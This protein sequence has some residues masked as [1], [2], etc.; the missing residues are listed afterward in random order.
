MR[1]GIGLPG[2]IPG[3]DGATVS[4]WA[5]RAEAR[6][7]ASLI[8]DERLA[9]KGLDSM[10]VAAAAAAVTERIRITASVMVAPLRTNVALFAKQVASVDRYSNGRFTLGLGVGSREDDFALSGVDLHQRG[11]LTDELLEQAVAL[12]SDTSAAFGPDTVR[13]GGPPLLFGGRSPATFRRVARYG[14]GWICATS[15]G[16]EGLRDGAARLEEAWAAAGRE[17]SPE[18]LALSPRFALGPNGRQSVDDYVRAYN[19]YRGAGA[20]QRAASALLSPQD[21]QEQIARFAEVGCQEMVMNPA[22]PDPDEVDR[23]ADAL[24]AEHLFN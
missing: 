20:D 18:L 2:L 1:I 21:V 12:W 17:G 23:L 16:P 6:G 14:T 15:G 8:I 11:R 4:E 5:R 9:W 13:R 10:V 7:F 3:V 19:A 22:D 24:G